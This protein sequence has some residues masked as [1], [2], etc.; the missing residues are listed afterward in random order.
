VISV[1]VLEAPL[2]SLVLCFLNDSMK[3]PSW[4]KAA[5]DAFNLSLRQEIIQLLL[6]IKIALPIF[7]ESFFSRVDNPLNLGST[8]RQTDFSNFHFSVVA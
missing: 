7:G 4:P 6:D 5:M 3:S 2:V 1:I 8:H